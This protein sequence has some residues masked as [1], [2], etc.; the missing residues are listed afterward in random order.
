MPSPFFHRGNVDQFF[1]FFRVSVSLFKWRSWGC[2]RLLMEEILHHL[3][4][5]NLVNNGITYL[6]TGAG[7]CS[8]TL[9]ISCVS[10][11]CDMLIWIETNRF[12]SSFWDR[13]IYG[14]ILSNF[15]SKILRKSAVSFKRSKL[16]R[17]PNCTGVQRIIGIYW[18]NVSIKACCKSNIF[19]CMLNLLDDV[20]VS[21]CTSYFLL[22]LL[23]VKDVLFFLKQIH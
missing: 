15:L 18:N 8:S 21:I 23:V 12:A 4:S 16:G 5:I 9:T 2:L 13:R 7:F 17:P 6:P 1:F 20:W 3:E 10:V 14:C 22:G 19:S 11:M